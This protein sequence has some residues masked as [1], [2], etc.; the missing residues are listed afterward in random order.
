VRP[1]RIV[2]RKRRHT[3]HGILT[4]TWNTFAALFR[5]V[6][7]L[8]A[9]SLPYALLGAIVVVPLMLLS[10]LERRRRGRKS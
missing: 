9:W 3:A 8:V 5:R 6:G 10:L 7:D 1:G 2:S 4:D